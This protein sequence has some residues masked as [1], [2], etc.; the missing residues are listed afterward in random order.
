MILCGFGIT[1]MQVVN[2]HAKIKTKTVTG[3]RAPYMN[4]ELRRAINVRNMLKRKY[5]RVKTAANWNSYRKQ[6][7]L[8]TRL[9]KNSLK[10]VLIC[11]TNAIISL[12]ITIIVESFGRL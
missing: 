8:V 7:N 11:T 1:T 5:T 4:G 3:Q 2:E 10:H 12:K 6:R 9:H